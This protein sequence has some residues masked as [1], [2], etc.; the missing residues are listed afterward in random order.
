[1]ATYSYPRIHHGVPA[2]NAFSSSSQIM[3]P[4]FFVIII[5]RD[6]QV[7]KNLGSSLPWWGKHRHDRWVVDIHILEGKAMHAAEHSFFFQPQK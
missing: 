3:N 2:S 5:Q 7:R 1:M 4:L 6:F